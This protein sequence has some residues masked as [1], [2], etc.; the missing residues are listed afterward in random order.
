M[1][2][3][4]LQTFMG[5]ICATRGEKFRTGDVETT[6]SR[7]ISTNLPNFPM[8]LGYPGETLPRQVAQGERA[9]G[10]SRGVCFEPEPSAGAAGGDS[11]KR[12]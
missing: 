7:Y 8:F 2:H 3:S 11:S 6:C 12:E 5:S 1:G 4:K 10:Y 9:K